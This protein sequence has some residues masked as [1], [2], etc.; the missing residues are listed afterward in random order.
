MSNVEKPIFICNPPSLDKGKTSLHNYSKRRENCHSTQSHCRWWI[1]RRALANNLQLQHWWPGTKGYLRAKTTDRD[2]AILLLNSAPCVKMEYIN[3]GGYDCYNC[4][5]K[6][7]QTSH[8]HLQ[9]TSHNVRPCQFTSPRN[10]SVASSGGNGNF[11][12]YKAINPLHRCPS[13]YNAATQWWFEELKGHRSLLPGTRNTD[14]L[15]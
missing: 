13:G 7:S 3:I 12:F 14:I 8:W 15:T 4:T 1:Q 9:T 10:G 6:M 5:A 2:R 11:G